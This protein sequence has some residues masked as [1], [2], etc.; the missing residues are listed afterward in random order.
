MHIDYATADAAALNRTHFRPGQ[1]AGHYESFYQRG[2]HP[3]EPRAFWIRYTIFSPADMPDAAI[4]ELWAVY[5]DG[6]TGEHVVAKEEYPIA[7]CEFSPDSFGAR[8]GDRVLEPGVLRGQ[9]YGTNGHIAWDLTY[10]GDEPPLLLLPRRC[11]R[12]GFPKAK[13][14]VGSRSRS[15]DGT[16]TVN[17]RTIGIDGWIGSQNHNWGSRHTDYYAFGQV[18]GLRQRTRQLPRDRHRAHRIAGP[19]RTPMVTF[20]VLRHKGRDH[21]LVSLRQALRAKADFGYFY[22]NF[23]SPT[24]SVTI[25]GRFSASRSSSSGSTT[26]TRPAGSSTA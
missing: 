17:G 13:S 6:V 23:A 1:K 4:G 2:N 7:E 8:V 18:A 19:V 21:S 26:T 3:T 16:L 25:R 5:F 9:A 12:G 15:I 11:T 22:W 20:L 14:L 10:K 24:T